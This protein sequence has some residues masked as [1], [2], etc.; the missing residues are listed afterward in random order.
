MSRPS[1]PVVCDVGSTSDDE[2][3]VEVDKS[4]KVEDKRHTWDSHI[5]EWLMERLAEPENELL[6]SLPANIKGSAAKQKR[7]TRR[8]VLYEEMIALKPSH[9]WTEKQFETHIKNTRQRAVNAKISHAK[10]VIATGGGKAPLSPNNAEQRLAAAVSL[11]AQPLVYNNSSDSGKQDVQVLPPACV[12]KRSRSASASVACDKPAVTRDDPFMTMREKE[13]DL[14]VKKMT[15][16]IELLN[17]K[18]MRETRKR[19]KLEK[20]I[21]LLDRQLAASDG[22]TRAPAPFDPASS[23]VQPAARTFNYTLPLQPE[24]QMGYA[25]N[26]A[27]HHMYGSSSRMPF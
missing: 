8:R 21:T 26:T 3:V 5:T 24:P 4:K 23:T 22:S 6:L 11:P 13:H 17:E 10:D 19:L 18:K 14:L 1:V 20:Q 9:A 7:K 2:E 12:S 27:D 16:E 15:L 25:G